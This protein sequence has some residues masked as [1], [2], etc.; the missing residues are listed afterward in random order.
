M[1]VGTGARRA[2][3]HPS[4]K[5]RLGVFLVLFVTGSA[6]AVSLMVSINPSPLVV[7]GTIVLG[8]ASAIAVATEVKRL[9]ERHGVIEVL[10]AAERARL[11]REFVAAR[12]GERRTLWER[13]HDDVLQTT[14]GNLL[15]LDAARVLLEEGRIDQARA[16]MSEAARTERRI[17]GDLRRLMAGLSVDPLG[18]PGGDP[19]QVLVAIP[20]PEREPPVEK[21]PDRRKALA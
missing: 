3:P 10:E 1:D 5:V 21:S 11:L 13:L 17:F 7:T 2:L 20:E 18:N 12:E 19:L 8:A 14:A 6:A 16:L 9:R 4:P 15:R